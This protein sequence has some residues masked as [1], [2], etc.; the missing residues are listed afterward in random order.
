VFALLK[1]MFSPKNRDILNRVIF[2]LAVLFVFKLGTVIQVPGTQAIASDKLGFLALM[3]AMGGGAFKQFSIFALGV[4]PYISASIITQLLQMDI[5]PYFS[6]LAKQ[7]QS[8]RTKINKINRYFR[9]S[10][11]INYSDCWNCILIVDR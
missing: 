4:M 10:K 3:D 9:I 5:V 6:D 1:Q 11:N 7:G 8:G 2:T